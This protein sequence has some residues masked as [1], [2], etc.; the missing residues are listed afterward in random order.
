[1]R[2]AFA[3]VLVKKGF[4][5]SPA[6]VSGST[7]IIEPSRLVASVGVRTSWLRS[8][9]PSAVGG[10]GTPPTA[11]PGSPQALA[12]ATPLSWPQST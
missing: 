8:A 2:R 3:S 10:E 4:P 6:P 12:G 11:A 1:M 9:P 5:G 7:R